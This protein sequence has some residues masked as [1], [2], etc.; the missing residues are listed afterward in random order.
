MLIFKK[1]NLIKFGLNLNIK[2]L[3]KYKFLNKL[4]L[5]N[6]LFFSIFDLKFLI[7]KLLSFYTF[8]NLYI[9]NLKNT[10]TLLFVDGSLNKRTQT[11][12]KKY[13]LQYNYFYINKNNW[14]PIFEKNLQIKKINFLIFWNY[15]SFFFKINPFFLNIPFFFFFKSLLSY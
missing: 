12:N 7:Y 11:I 6:K 3:S 4:I 1:K 13:L 8:N 2:N 9:K 15:N 10:R 14:L 5:S